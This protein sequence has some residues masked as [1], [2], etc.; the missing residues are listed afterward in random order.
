MGVA[1]YEFETDDELEWRWSKSHILP[2]EKE[3]AIPKQEEI[4]AGRLS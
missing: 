1:Q 2:C 3:I 4:G